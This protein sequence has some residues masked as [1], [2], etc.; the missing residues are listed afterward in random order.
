MTRLESMNAELERVNGLEREVMNAPW[1]K[2]APF[3]KR[4]RELWD[5]INAEKRRI[6]QEAEKG[7]T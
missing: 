5:D 7:T 1:H 3:R 4:R 6:A 2:K